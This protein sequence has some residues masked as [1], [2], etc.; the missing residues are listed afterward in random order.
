VG[1]VEI[2]S[3]AAQYAKSRLKGIGLPIK[4][5]HSFDPSLPDRSVPLLVLP[6][7]LLPFS[8]R[9]RGACSL[10]AWPFWR[11]C[12]RDGGGVDS[13]SS[14]VPIK[15]RPAKVM[16]FVVL[17]FHM[18]FNFSSLVSDRA[19]FRNLA[20]QH[21]NWT[22]KDTSCIKVST[23]HEKNKSEFSFLRTLTIGTIQCFFVKEYFPVPS[24]GGNQCKNRHAPS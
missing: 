21:F 2:L 3:A 17:L 23:D 7:R 5:I 15:F 11:F 6:F 10:C 19:N 13:C 12:T 1:S 20:Q 22:K 16:S 18:K 8:F 14:C 9:E 4:Q 24:S